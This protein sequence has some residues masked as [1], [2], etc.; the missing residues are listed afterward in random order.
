MLA[1]ILQSSQG[2]IS[3]TW[4]LRHI[5]MDLLPLC[6]KTLTI[7]Y[8]LVSFAVV[9]AAGCSC[10]NPWR[11]DGPLGIITEDINLTAT[12]SGVCHFLSLPK[13]CSRLVIPKVGG[14]LL[15]RAR[16]YCR[17]AAEQIN[18]Y[19]NHFYWFHKKSLTCNLIFLAESDFFF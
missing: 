16:S 6:V 1:N 11:G 14:R 12:K 9:L 10:Y 7:R 17:G 19:F 5:I 18:F 2:S 8:I 4:T 13:S 3:V 15:H